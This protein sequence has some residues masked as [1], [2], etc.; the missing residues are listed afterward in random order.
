MQISGRKKLHIGESGLVPDRLGLVSLDASKSKGVIFNQVVHS[1]DSIFLS[2]DSAWVKAGDFME[3]EGPYG[4]GTVFSF[5]AGEEHIVYMNSQEF[6]KQ[7]IDTKEVSR[8]LMHGYGVFG[9]LEY[10]AISVP[11]SP[12]FTA[13]DARTN[14][15]YFVYVNDNGVSVIGYNPAVDSME[16]IPIPLDSANFF[17]LRFEVRIKGLTLSG[18]DEPQLS[19][20]GS[21]LI[22]SYP[23][24]SDIFVYDLQSGSRQTYTPTSNSFPSRKKLPQNYANEVDSFELLDELEKSWRSQVRYGTMV[25]LEGLEKFVRLVKGEGGTEPPYF[26]EVFDSDFKKSNEF[27]L[28]EMNPDL[29]GS[30]L[31]TKYGL[32]FRAKDQPRE[33]VMYYYNL[34][35]RSSK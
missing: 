34:T 3:T 6:F 2:A 7:H 32:M 22:V 1:L 8:K 25:Y 12:E 9:D 10:P 5:F 24:F 16:V 18:N 26:M 11:N 31:N 33:D 14:T 20:V 23:S 35:I 29:S 19:V 17:S 13:M 28:T 21:R 15:A 30:Y 27:N 4:V